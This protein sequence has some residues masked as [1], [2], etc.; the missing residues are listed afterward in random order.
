[1]RSVS[2]FVLFLLIFLSVFSFMKLESSRCFN[3][4]RPRKTEHRR[5]RAPCALP[6]SLERGLPPPRSLRVRGATALR[7]S[8]CCAR[9]PQQRSRSLYDR[10]SLRGHVGV[11]HP[12][13]TVP[14]AQPALHVSG[15][16]RAHHVQ[17]IH[18]HRR[19]RSRVRD[20]RGPPPSSRPVHQALSHSLELQGACL[21]R[22]LQRSG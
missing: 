20:H 17:G 7:R 14:A 22:C 21:A 16:G 4:P 15:R 19:P 3:R 10:E 8:R 6:D 9:S 1:M 5:R 2:T 13:A 18:G 12:T 11:S